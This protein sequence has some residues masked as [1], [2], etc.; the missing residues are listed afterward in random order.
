[1]KAI[2]TYFLAIRSFWFRCAAITR[3]LCNWTWPALHW[4]LSQAAI[5]Q[6][7]LSRDRS[8]TL[9]LMPSGDCDEIRFLLAIFF[10]WSIAS[11]NLDDANSAHS[12]RFSETIHWISVNACLR[13]C[14]C[15]ITKDVRR[16]FRGCWWDFQLLGMICTPWSFVATYRSSESAVLD[17]RWRC[18]IHSVSVWILISLWE[19][20]SPPQKN[21]RTQRRT[22]WI[23]AKSA[24]TI[25]QT[26]NKVR[27]HGSGW[28][29][30]SQKTHSSVA[31][32]D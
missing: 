29:W 23:I 15:V 21:A 32:T 6:M 20:C 24:G 9:S 8:M 17:F 28:I 26:P 13:L 12:L 27:S 7:Y 31:E 1:M 10:N 4:E 16:L 5:N 3:V 2:F 18:S 25:V 11:I 22:R 19:L 30:K 14:E